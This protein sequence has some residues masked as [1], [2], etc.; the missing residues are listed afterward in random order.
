MKVLSPLILFLL[1]TIA[2]WAYSPA[3][4][5]E[6]E[7]D[8]AT[9]ELVYEKATEDPNQI[10]KKKQ[11]FGLSI[12]F[13]QVNGF[14]VSADHI[15]EFFL[16]GLYNLNEE[17][18]FSVLQSL[19]RNYFLNPNSED[20][21]LWIQDP[22]FITQRSFLKLPL[23]SLLKIG[24]STTA[25][26]S[27]KSQI[28]DILTVSSVYFSWSL[29]LDPLLK[30]QS[31]WAKNFV[32]FFQPVARYYSSFYK[33]SR[34]LGQSLGGTP[35]PEFLTGIQKIGFSFDITDYFYLTGSYGRWVIFPY[36]TKYGR[37]S[38]SNYDSYYQR[39][40]YSFF[41]ETGLNI[42]PGWDFAL[43]YSLTDRLDRQ[44][45]I[46]TVLFDDR[47]S[48]WAVS[49]SYSFAFD[50]INFKGLKSLLK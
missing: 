4:A 13:Q 5:D 33:T 24:L 8:T 10:K 29:K 48:L 39:H 27:Y 9:L 36:K 31:K 35:L 18:S 11:Q 14:I 17:W 3:L 20:Q 40:Y 6:D 25:P 7:L 47:L 46:E 12:G 43:S 30:W 16:K 1:L 19:N 37:D 38:S 22:V 15:S 28:N 23:N 26:L 2:W 32:I 42:K 49:V 50:S 41:L 45:R 34:T 44:G 21:G